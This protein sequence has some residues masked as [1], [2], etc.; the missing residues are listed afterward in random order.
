MSVYFRQLLVPLLSLHCANDSS[1]VDPD[2]ECLFKAII[3]SQVIDNRTVE[4]TASDMCGLA[5]CTLDTFELSAN[6]RITIRLGSA[7]ASHRRDRR[8]GGFF[9][10]VTMPMAAGSGYR[11]EFNKRATRRNSE[12]NKLS[13][14]RYVYAAI[15]ILMVRYRKITFPRSKP[16]MSH[17]IEERLFASLMLSDPSAPAARVCECHFPS[18]GRVELFNEY[19][20]PSPFYNEMRSYFYNTIDKTFGQ[21]ELLFSSDKHCSLNPLRYIR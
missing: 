5:P 19:R 18:V 15:R 9:A 4:I 1:R 2:K 3:H 10:S 13:C 6:D 14:L 20:L 12:D 21:F 8:T 7:A 11:Y 16:L 17:K